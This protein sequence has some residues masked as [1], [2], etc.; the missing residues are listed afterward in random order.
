MEKGYLS[1]V[2]HAHLPYVRHPEH[3]RFLEEEWFY[4]AITETYLPLI[5]AFR[6]LVRDGVDFRITMSLTP[7]LLSMMTDPMLQSRYLKHLDRLIELSRREIERTA[8]DAAF[9]ALAV[10]Y[11]GLFTEAR[12]IFHDQYHNDLTRAFREF[13]D[14]GK[15]EIMTCGATHGFLPLMEVHTQAVRAQIRTAVQ[16][17]ERILGR[18]PRGIWLPECGYYPGLDEILKAEGIKFFIIDTHGI[19]F[20]SPRPKYGVFAPVY[21]KSGVAAFGRDIESSKSVWSAEEGYP[22]DAMYREF[23]RDIG[24]D[25]DY[26]YIRPYLNGDGSRINTGIKYYRITGTTPNKEPYQPEAARQKAAEHA[27]NFMFNREKQVEYLHDLMGRQPL[28]VSPY[29]AELYGHWWFEGPIWLEYLFRKI[30]HDQGVFKTITPMEYLEKFPKNQVI[31]PSM[32][33]WGYNG[34]AEVWLNGSNDWIYR[35]LHKAVER[36]VEA[37]RHR[38]AAGGLERRALNQMARELLLAQSSDWAFIM[39]TGT[40]T[41]YAVQR[42][43]DHLERFT[44]LWESVTK[45]SI[46]TGYLERIESTDNLFPGID[47]KVYA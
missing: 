33:S 31:T 41:T 7:T 21:T 40:H 14:M 34:Y 32:S 6:A 12:H 45:N 15:L 18:K 47:Y 4:E 8:G 37:A 23:Y 44:R 36:M 9:Q 1:I 13:Q 16:T 25:L 30:H 29:D 27:G 2:L 10:M 42:T 11:H 3:E 43:K 17:H 28:I 26:D 46:D 22:G 35:H 20:G 39:K 24:F 5:K 19:L 38:P